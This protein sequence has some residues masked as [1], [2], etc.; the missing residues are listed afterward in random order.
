V[1]QS[2]L[3]LG[4]VALLSC[5]LAV[6]FLHGLFHQREELSVREEPAAMVR[7]LGL[8]DLCLFT[9]AR[10]TRHPSQADLHTAFQDHPLSLEHFPSGSLLGPS[11][12]LQ[13]SYATLD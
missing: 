5:V 8:T 6:L 2:S 9:E 7:R 3:F 11:P 1:R 4:T 13:R 12:T 10:Y